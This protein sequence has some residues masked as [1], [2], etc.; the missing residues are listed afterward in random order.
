MK[1]N[2]KVSVVVLTYNHEKYIKRALESILNQKTNFSYE[3]LIGDDCST[4][5]SWNI[6]KEYKKQ[7]P[8]IIRIFQAKYNMGATKNSYHLFHKA[9]GEYIAQLETD[10]YWTDELKLQK[11]IDFLEE[12]RGYVGCSHHCTVVD[13]NEKTIERFNNDQKETY[14]NFCSTTF[15]LKDFEMGKYPGHFGTMV[16]RNIFLSPD[17]DYRILYQAHRIIGDRTIIGLLSI[18][19]QIYVLK[20]NMSCYRMIENNEAQNW[21]S[22]ARQK[23]KRYEEFHYICELER[24]MNVNCERAVSM[25]TVRQEKIVCASVYMLDHFNYENVK[26]V[27]QMCLDNKSTIGAVGLA[28]SSIFQKMF[29]RFICG[30]DRPVVY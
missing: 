13:Q 12:N 14:W 11:Q 23:N 29:Y 20:D 5:N 18:S 28:C 24:Y 21:Q 30:E 10:D 2:V 8:E 15:T 19:G 7:Y 9:S 27:F 4:D 22:Q 16:Y 6:L 25:K 17:L 26:V 3:I 1:R